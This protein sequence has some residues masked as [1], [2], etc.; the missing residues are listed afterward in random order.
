MR[1]FRFPFLFLLA[2]VTLGLACGDDGTTPDPGPG[3]DDRTLHL[4]QD[5]DYVR[6]TF[7]FFD[8]ENDF[9]GPV[10]TTVKV[11]RTVLPADLIADPTIVSV[12]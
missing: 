4:I 9:I 3:P 2:A 1:T 6:N 8:H 7:F 10:A 11:Y 5:I 12:P